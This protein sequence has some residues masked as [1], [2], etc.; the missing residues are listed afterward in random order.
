MKFLKALAFALLAAGSAHAA[1]NQTID[2]GLVKNGTLPPAAL[3]NSSANAVLAGPASGP[4][5]ATT[6]RP[7]VAADIPSLSDCNTFLS[8]PL[9]GQSSQCGLNSTLASDVFSLLSTTCQVTVTQGVGTYTFSLPTFVCINANAAARQTQ[10]TG[11]VLQ[12]TGADS[13]QSYIDFDT[14]AAAGS[15]TFRRADGTGA[16]PSA[17]QLGEVLGQISARGYG[18]T[19]YSAASRAN[20]QFLAGQ[21][22]TD[23]AQGAG[24]TFNTTP[25]GG[26][27]TAEAAR[28]TPSGD[29][30]IGTTTDGNGKL[31]VS[32][33]TSAPPTAIS[34]SVMQLTGAD[35]TPSFLDFDVFAAAPTFLGRR[36]DGTNASPTAVQSGEA[37]SNWSGRGYGATGYSTAARGL[38]SM[39]AD[40]NWTDSAQGTRIDCSTT[41]DTTTT[42]G[43]TFRVNAGKGTGIAMAGSTSGL[44]TIQ[45]AAAA[46][47]TITLPA[48]TTD[49][50][51]TGGASQVV[52]QTSAGS[53]FTVARLACADLSDST[54]ACSTATGTSGATI[55]LLNGPNTWS[56]LQTGTAGLTIT[57]AAAQLNV[58]SNFSVLLGTGTSTGT[59]QLGGSAAQTIS[60]G[61]SSSAAKTLT[62]GSTN[63]SSTLALQGPAGGI[64]LVGTSTGTAADVMCLTSG[65]VIILQAAGSCTISSLRFKELVKDAFTSWLQPIREVMALRPIAFYMKPMLHPNPDNNFY[66]EQIGLSAENVAAVDP[67]IAMV[68]QD[69]ET[70]KAYR[71]E[72]MISLLTATVQV[73]QREIYVLVV[74]CFGLTVAVVFLFIR[75]RS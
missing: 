19:G 13:Q 22:W 74:W 14:F 15:L 53:A 10:I 40:E 2:G 66:R 25:N 70:P 67:R 56:A 33:N 38:C 68:E 62:I 17:V 7:L 23:S 49:F 9:L 16:S 69:G 8:T 4:P 57:G 21:N 26:T 35:T 28:F 39:V 43:V 6:S 54:S 65:G 36:A 11:S 42:T 32:A 30:L 20:M 5:G 51:A 50:S 71:P 37:L 18:A 24:I 61:T 63:A 12:L 31:Q 72:A 60:I 34:G 52:K 27:S 3:S 1:S 44:T 58:N 48:G 41:A 59:I 45:P 55:P 47:G 64:S 73:Q 75:K 46:S 29:L